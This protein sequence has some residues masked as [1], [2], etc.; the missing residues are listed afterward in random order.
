MTFIITQRADM[1][2]QEIIHKIGAILCASAPEAARK[3]LVKAAI[4]PENDGGEYEFDYLDEKG[5]LDFF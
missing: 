1:D 2:D 5:N 3:I 4:F